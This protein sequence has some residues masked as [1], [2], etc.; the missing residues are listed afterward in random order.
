MEEQIK[1][2]KKKLEDL[3][4]KLEDLK[5]KLKELEDKKNKIEGIVASGEK[6][7]REKYTPP[8]PPPPVPPPVSEDVRKSINT[9]VAWTINRMQQVFD[10]TD[11]CSA[12]YECKVL[13][14]GIDAETGAIE[15]T[16]TNNE[17]G[18]NKPITVKIDATG[19]P[20]SNIT[21]KY[22]TKGTKVLPSAAT[23]KTISDDDEKNKKVLN[24]KAIEYSTVGAKKCNMIYVKIEIFDTN[25]STT[26]PICGKKLLIHIAADAPVN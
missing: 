21:G 13:V 19:P 26:K 10:G 4:K 17:T 11:T 18:A 5:K 14:D 23:E 25:K 8:L 2:A 12:E 9:T 16:P 6:I 7:I 3:K 1:E 24:G 22:S 15:I 20:K